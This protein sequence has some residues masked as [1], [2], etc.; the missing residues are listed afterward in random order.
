MTGERK[1]IERET[2]L[3]FPLANGKYDREHANKHFIYG[4]ES[5]REWLENLPIADV[6]PIVYGEWLPVDEM[7]DAFDCSECDAMVMRRYHFCPK[8]GANMRRR[9]QIIKTEEE[10]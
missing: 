4:C 3:S 10:E 2:A 7:K 5:Y 9:T 1:F 8:C 6:Q